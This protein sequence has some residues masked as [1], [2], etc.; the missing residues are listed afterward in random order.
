MFL[1]AVMIAYVSWYWLGSIDVSAKA[2]LSVHYSV[3]GIGVV[4]GSGYI[5]LVSKNTSK[6]IYTF[7]ARTS[8]LFYMALYIVALAKKAFL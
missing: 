3:I 8:V 6:W 7:L 2:K 1:I 4:I 5:L